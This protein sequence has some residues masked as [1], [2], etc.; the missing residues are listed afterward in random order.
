MNHS[1]ITVALN[2]TCSEV[3]EVPVR[4]DIARELYARVMAAR[5]VHGEKRLGELLAYSLLSSL[6]PLVPTGIASRPPT[7]AQVK[8]AMD[9]SRVLGLELPVGALQDRMI[10]GNF[11]SSY[12]DQLYKQRGRAA[13]EKC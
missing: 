2:D 8:F 1:S 12:G 5:E 13:A 4:S 7:A 6:M 11:I 3:L 10:I 9:I